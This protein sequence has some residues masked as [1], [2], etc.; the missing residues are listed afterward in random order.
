MRAGACLLIAA[1][2]LHLGNYIYNNEHEYFEVYKSFI[3]F[4]MYLVGFL[5]LRKGFFKNGASFLKKRND[6]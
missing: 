4:I 1:V 6:E 2:I 3:I 5:M